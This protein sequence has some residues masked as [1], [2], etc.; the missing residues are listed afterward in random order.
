LFVLLAYLARFRRPATVDVRHFLRGADVKRMFSNILVGGCMEEIGSGREFLE[1]H[2]MQMHEARKFMLAIFHDMGILIAWSE[3]ALHMELVEKPWEAD[4]EVAEDGEKFVEGHRTLLAAAKEFRRYALFKLVRVNI[5]LLF[6][7]HW[8]LRW[9]MPGWASLTES[10][11]GLL[12]VYGKIFKAVVEVTAL[13]DEEF[14]EEF[15]KLL[16]KIEDPAKEIAAWRE[17]GIILSS[18]GVMR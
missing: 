11:R 1:S 18:P 16:F 10:G 2:R 12:A 6:H 13:Y 3:G 5:G 8:M 14:S 17:T 4:G 7:A 15:L 9:T